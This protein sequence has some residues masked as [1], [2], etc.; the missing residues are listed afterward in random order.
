[1]PEF[2]VEATRIPVF[3]ISESYLFTYYFEGEDLFEELEGYYDRDEY[4][5][6]IPKE[7]FEEVCRVLAEHFYELDVVE[8]IEPYCV[9]KETYTEHAEILKQSVLTWTRRGHHFFLLKDELAVEH[10]IE[11]GATPVAD[12]DLVLGI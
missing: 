11:R 6:E 3:E 5:F 10:A 7:A 2:D 9:V 1:M 12:V 4:R 8:D